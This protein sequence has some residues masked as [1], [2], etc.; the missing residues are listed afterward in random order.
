MGK[1]RKRSHAVDQQLDCRYEETSRRSANQKSLKYE[2]DVKTSTNSSIH[3]PRSFPPGAASDSGQQDDKRS[4]WNCEMKSGNNVNEECI[5]EGDSSQS[6]GQS[7]PAPFSVDDFKVEPD[8]DEQ[9]EPIHYLQRL[10][11]AR[12]KQQQQLQQQPQ[13]QEVV[14]NGR[15]IHG[16]ASS[17][18]NPWTWPTP[19]QLHLWPLMLP[20]IVSFPVIA[21][22][23]TSSGKTLAYGLPILARAVAEAVQPSTESGQLMALIVV[24]TRELCQQVADELK[25]T[26]RALVRGNHQTYR[27]VMPEV[28]ACYAGSS[29]KHEQQVQLK[30]WHDDQYNRKS[31]LILSATPGRLFDLI[32]PLDLVSA[33]K[34]PGQEAT[35][36]TDLNT[37]V[38]AILQ[39]V[40]G[41]VRYV[42]LDEADRLG[43]GRDLQH[44]V[45]RILSLC[46]VPPQPIA[47][48]PVLRDRPQLILCSATWPAAVK[49]VWRDWIN[50]T[51][52]S[53]NDISNAA[54][55]SS[56]QR[57]V[58]TPK[59]C[60]QGIPCMVIRVDSMSVNRPESE[61]VPPETSQNGAIRESELKLPSSRFH[62]NLTLAR[63]PLHLEQTVHVCAEHKKPRKLLQTLARMVQPEQDQRAEDTDLA[64]GIVFF[65]KIVKIQHTMR[66]LEKEEVA[67]LELH[68]QLPQHARDL[69]IRNF[70]SGKVRLLLATDVAARG[71]HVDNIRFVINYDFPGNLEQ[72]VHRCGR[73]GRGVSTVGTAGGQRMYKI[74]SFFTRNLSPLAPDLVSLLDST[75]QWVDPNLRSL[76]QEQ[77]GEAAASPVLS[78][79]QKRRLDRTTTREG[80]K[81]D[82]VRNDGAVDLT[83]E[84]LIKCESN[85]TNHGPDAEV[86][87]DDDVAEWMKAHNRI[88]LK[89]AENIS[90]PSSP[91]EDEE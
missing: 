49:P 69:A 83:P 75:Q 71:L 27:G 86:G 30:N 21:V 41:T 1:R 51:T 61:A 17:F 81:G 15:T 64:R 33:D 58:E 24:P 82:N 76:A 74:F 32:E 70:R 23:P 8:Q 16:T 20:Q 3:S 12:Q 60:S 9:L 5:N 79:R 67:C 73:A 88:V 10:W 36:T 40:L 56:T 2:A 18:R 19:V 80:G 43:L 39:T 11:F 25:S 68:S 91:S 38:A 77:L 72:Y 37:C 46:A 31:S 48:T 35:T 54:D 62:G 55:A 85:G 34:T 26:I 78:N 47:G 59:T 84:S 65:N 28:L 89:R 29:S 52:R 7:V 66:L 45:S 53:H 22:A 90:D 63:I 4:W 87:S 44:Q 50:L 42:V 57:E 6:H 13:Q 14:N